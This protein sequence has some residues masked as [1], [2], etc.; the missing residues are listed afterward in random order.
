MKAFRRILAPTDLTPESL[1]AVLFAG[2]LGR[3]QGAELTVLHVATSSSMVYQEM[4]PPVD[5]SFID[6]EIE[7]HAR[8]HLEKWARKNLRGY[9]KLKLLVR[10]GPASDTICSTAE[11]TRANLIVMATHGRAGLRHFIVGSVTEQVLRDAPCPVLT[12]NPE[13]QKAAK[14]NRK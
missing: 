6:E 7:A 11:E 10:S 5:V 3:A 8:G 1:S 9:E 13:H 2:H 14:K 12:V 4:L